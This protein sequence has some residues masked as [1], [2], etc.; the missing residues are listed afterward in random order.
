MSIKMLCKITFRLQEGITMTRMMP[1]FLMLSLTGCASNPFI[2]YYYDSGIPLAN[3]ASYYCEPKIIQGINPV[4]DYEQMIE[5]NYG[6]LGYASFNAANADERKALQQAIN[7]GAEIVRTYSKYSGTRSGIMPINSHYSQN[8]KA[9]ISTQAYGTAGFE[10]YNSAANSTTYGEYTTYVPYS[11]DRY[12][13]LATFWRKMKSPIL[14][15][16]V[17]DLSMET[18]QIIGTNRGVFVSIV[19]LNS[20]A[21]KAD[22]FKGD[23]ITKINNI[24][25]YGKNILQETINKL[26]GQKVIVEIL[27][28][29]KTIRK[30][31]QLLQEEKE[32][33]T[34]QVDQKRVTD[35]LE[36]LQELLYDGTITDKEYEAHKKKLL[37]NQ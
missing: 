20:P 28:K 35:K 21:Y 9:Q 23:I 30:E 26:S 2:R 12:D 31:I 32:L 19:I 27:R 17:D 7:V 37:T 36:E 14:G 15:A 18:R 11:I 4:T 34:K 29:G 8:S 3:T 10:N 1:L 22:I 6:L 33:S 13:Y 5:E 16:F 25:I 24:E